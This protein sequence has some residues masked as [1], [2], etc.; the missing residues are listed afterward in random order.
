MAVSLQAL[1]ERG[2]G[3]E[4]QMAA[5]LRE[6]SAEPR[7]RCE[8]WQLLGPFPAVFNSPLW[9]RRRSSLPAPAAVWRWSR[10]SI[11]FLGVPFGSGCPVGPSHGG[12]RDLDGGAAEQLLP[13]LFA[14]R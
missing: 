14:V 10:H 12:R 1:R 11:Q 8:G 6:V 13:E 3:G 7:A 4:E 2:C 5:V 9:W